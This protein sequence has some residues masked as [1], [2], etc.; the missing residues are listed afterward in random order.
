MASSAGHVV[1]KAGY[2]FFGSH[3]N[4]I[5]VADHLPSELFTHLYAGFAK[6]NDDGN[7]FIPD[8][9]LELFQ[10]FTRTVRVRNPSVKTLLSIGGEGEEAHIST[11]VANEVKRGHLKR[12]SINLAKR[13]GFDGLD[14]CWLYPSNADREDQLSALLCEWRAALDKDKEKTKRPEPWLLTAAVFHHPVI[15]DKDGNITFSYP[16]QAISDN[17]DW[18]NVLAI[19]FYTPSN[20][21]E[22]T[23]PVHAW[24]TRP[25]D[26]NDRCG[27]IGIR[28]WI[29]SGFVT[30]K[31]VLGLPFYGYEW[32]L[33][34]EKTEFGFFAPARVQRSDSLSY[35]DIQKELKRGIYETVYYRPYEA[36]Y[37]HEVNGKKWI[38]YDDGC[39]ITGKVTKAL[40]VD[41]KL[42]GYFAWHLEDDDCNWTL[43]RSASESSQAEV[44][45]P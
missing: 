18:I 44:N 25:I 13:F 34:Y 35:R 36:V 3:D 27:K 40:F 31:L 9:Y 5:N 19:D 30:N 15:S 22:E 10:V 8:T 16:I 21:P 1:V 17:L 12:D 37:S 23:G 11:V 20:S 29:K 26:Q 43:S 7:V 42:G 6:V 45:Y 39:S 41:Y 33:V 4:R 14:L 38:G 2:W 24:F 32:K 28:D